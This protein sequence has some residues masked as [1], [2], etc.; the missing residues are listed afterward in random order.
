MKWFSGLK[1]LNIAK[2]YLLL[3]IRASIFNTCK[4][5][6]FDLQLLYER[7]G[8]KILMQPEPKTGAGFR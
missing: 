7:I 6:V 8:I 1:E 3:K 2:D 5:S 4:K